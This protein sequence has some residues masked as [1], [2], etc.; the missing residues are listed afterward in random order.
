MASESF[1]HI[2]ENK[3]YIVS[4]QG[5]EKGPYDNARQASSVLTKHEDYMRVM[6]G[7]QVKQTFDED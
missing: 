5:V 3:F 1:D 7:L 6:S 4:E 2:D